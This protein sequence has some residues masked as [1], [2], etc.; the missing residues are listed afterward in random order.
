NATY[1]ASP[2]TVQFSSAGSSDPDG[3]TINYS[4]NFGDGSAV[5]T[6]ANPSHIYS[7]AGGTPSK[8]V[9]TL[10]VTDTGGLSAQSSITI[11]VNDTPP[12]AAIT[13]F[14]DGSLF[15]PT[16]ATSLNLVGNVT[17][18][19]SPDSQLSY[20]WQTLLHHNNH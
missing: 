14:A 6:Q 5:S 12:N 2:L 7:V 10:T 16:V 1:G 4:W 3:Q 17:D 19:E 9:A 18:A 15:S 13:S 20:R 11:G 8:F